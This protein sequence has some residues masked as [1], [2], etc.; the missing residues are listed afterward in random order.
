M[1]RLIS[2]PYISS[3][4]RIFR[5]IYCKTFTILQYFFSRNSCCISFQYLK[6]KINSVI[7][8]NPNVGFQDNL[9]SGSDIG[10]CSTFSQTTAA[11]VAKQGSSAHNPSMVLTMQSAPFSPGSPVFHI[12]KLTGSPVEPNTNLARLEAEQKITCI[13]VLQKLSILMHKFPN[14]TSNPHFGLFKLPQA[15]PWP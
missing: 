9:H 12:V 3:E 13:F 15:T 14:P 6:K 4:T 5:K 2:V 7:F 8:N 10:S 1:T 11:S